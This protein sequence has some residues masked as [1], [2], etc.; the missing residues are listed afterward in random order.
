M[1]EMPTVEHFS[2]L[3]IGQIIAFSLCFIVVERITRPVLIWLA[4]NLLS[5][6]GYGLAPLQ[7]LPNADKALVIGGFLILFNGALKALAL[8]DRKALRRSNLWAHILAA[9]ALLAA[10]MLIFAI[11]TPYRM[12]LVATSGLLSSLSAILYLRG[13]RAWLGLRPAILTEAVLW[14]SIA[15]FVS[16]I[17]IAYPFG[18]VTR[19]ADPSSPLNQLMLAFL[20]F[21]LQISFLGLIVSRQLRE[22]Q[23]RARRAG[24]MKLQSIALKQK[25][26]ETASIAEERFQLL[27]MLTHEVRQPLN[28]AQAALQSVIEEVGHG[29]AKPDQLRAVLDRALV[30]INSIALSISNSILGATLITKGRTAQFQMIDLC[31]ISQMALLDISPGDRARIERSFAQDVIF[32]EAD[33][34]VLRLAIRNLLENALKYSPAKSKVLFQIQ[35]D[36]EEMEATFTIINEVADLSILEGDI[37]G[38]EKRGADSRY[39]GFGLGLYIVREVAMMHR[40]NLDYKVVDN[41][42]VAFTLHL[43][44]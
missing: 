37:F 6:I 7:M 17:A 8:S 44:C 43:P 29:N 1:I 5:V 34:I 25:Q 38:L 22:Q 33:P 9:A 42:K 21:L 35:V 11:D 4:S 30:T 27:K 14:L 20:Q 39:E 19:Y 12:L 13:N 23:F 18:D 41:K 16:R 40:G 10:L 24:R 3:F 36:E 26:R 2:F 31:S 28:T 15:A 32:A